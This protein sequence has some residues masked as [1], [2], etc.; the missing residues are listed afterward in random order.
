MTETTA[1]D[2]NVE[3]CIRAQTELF[4]NGRAQLADELVTWDCV[5][6][7]AP[8]EIPPGPEGIMAVVSWLHETFGD[9]QYQVEDAFGAGDRVALRCRV[10]GVLKGGL[11]GHPPTGR[12]FET[13]QIHLYRLADGRIVEHWGVRDDVTMMRQ[14]GL[15]GSDEA[16]SEPAQSSAA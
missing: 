15:L 1:V 8:L 6:H 2:T 9:L 16:G 5:D 13:A 10:S 4:G 7:S 11:G 12:R 3:L 14:V